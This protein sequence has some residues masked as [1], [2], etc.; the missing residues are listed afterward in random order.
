[1]VYAINKGNNKNCYFLWYTTIV[2]GLM[3]KGLKIVLIVIGVGVV[4]ILLDTI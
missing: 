3:K 4:I 2:G 1:M